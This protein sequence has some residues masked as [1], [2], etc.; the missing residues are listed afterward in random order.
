MYSEKVMDH[1]TNPR[2]VGEIADANAVGEVGNPTC[3]D[4]MRI[5]MKIE[6]G[7]ITDVKFKTFGCGAAVATSSMATEMVKGKTIAEALALTNK[8][9]AEALDGLPPIKMHC[10]VL[11][12]DAIKAA[13]IDYYK[14][15]G[16][17]P[18]PMVGLDSV[19]EMECCHG[20]LHEGCQHA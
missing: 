18:K 15:Q 14:R 19:A 13:L 1:F 20:D 11:A 6:D 2:N 5:Y 16:I 4:I 3:G 7:V 12:E 17:D 10:S 9:V 8:A